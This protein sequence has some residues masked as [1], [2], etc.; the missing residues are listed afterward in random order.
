L[1][2][3]FLKRRRKGVDEC[4]GCGTRWERGK[5]QNI[6]HEK[7]IFNY[8]HNMHV[9]V[10]AHAHTHTHTYEGGELMGFPLRKDGGA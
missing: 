1:D 9:Y 4:G 2:I 7:I 10:H 6:L 8:I 5:H 3:C